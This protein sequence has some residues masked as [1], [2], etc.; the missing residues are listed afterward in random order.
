MTSKESW[1]LVSV[2]TLNWNGKQFIDPFVQSFLALD[3][4]ADRLELI[5]ADNKSSDDSVAYLKK[6]YSD[7]PNIKLV[8]NGGNYGY[9]GGN[10]R[11]MHQ[12]T[13]EY[14]LVCNNDLI[15]EKNLLKEL[16]TTSI[17]HTSAVTVPKLMFLNKSGYINNAGS[18]LRPNDAWPIREIGYDQ[19]DSTQYSKEREITAFC[20]ACV[21][22]TREFLQHV[23]LFDNKF[24]MYFEDGDLSWRG[25]KAGYTFYFSP[26]ALAYHEHTGTS[27]EGSPLFN[28]YV[29]RNRLLIL[30]KHARLIV[31]FK[32]LYATLQDHLVLRLKNMFRAAL[33]RYGKRQA[34]SEFYLSQ[35]MLFA[36]LTAAPIEVLKRLRVIREERL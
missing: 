4:P 17:K 24:F 28:H 20:G 30:L 33:G 35:K 14:I 3:Y 5:F 18:E 12:A 16:L 26:K 10:N 1:P 25:Q 7:Q 9:A 13:G 21:L 6:H 23:G 19:K 31:F 36:F 2:V 29:G 8:Q 11:G 27:K 15:L 22:F 34:L 32:G